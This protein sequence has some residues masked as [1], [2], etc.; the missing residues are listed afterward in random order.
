MQARRLKLLPI[1]AAVVGMGLAAGSAQALDFHGYLR[2]GIGVSDKSGGQVCFRL[3][4][5][6]GNG[7]FRLGNECETYSEIELGQSLYEGKDGV[8]FDYHIMEAFVTNQNGDFENL[9][10]NGNQAALRQN[11]VEAKNLPFL[12]GGSAWVG[13]RYYQRHD[14]HINDFFYWDTSGPGAGIEKVKLGSSDMKG[15]FAIFRRNGTNVGNT[16]NGNDS[17]TAYDAR[18]HD[19][20]LGSAGSLEAGLLFN[21]ADTNVPNHKNG[22]SIMAEWSLPALGGVNKLFATSGSGSA[23]APFFA[24]PNNAPGDKDSSWGIQDTLQWQVSPQFSGMLAAGYYD[25]KNNYTWDFIGVRPVWH[26]SEYFK[27]QGE[28]SQ[29]WVKPQ[30]A[31]QRTL[32]HI[33]IAPTIVSGGGFWTRP[34]L[35][36]FYAYNK[37]ND[38]ARDGWGGVAGGTTGPYGT[39]TSGSTIGFQVEA[40]W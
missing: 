11:W 8:K 9:A 40:W 12:S 30:N 7:N 13:K 14:I 36:L 37:W 33:A 27:L 5:V 4:G 10:M 18:I 28:L 6:P 16:A 17:T 31:D 26:F 39:G 38:A 24:N 35:R 20:N 32:F 3:P 1:A 2:S 19:I 23:N 34:E 15:S 25:F 29:N 21:V 22:T